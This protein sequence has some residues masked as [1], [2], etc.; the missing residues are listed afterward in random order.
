MVT[1][2]AAGKKTGKLRLKKETIKDLDAKRT[3]KGGMVATAVYCRA[4]ATG[5]GGTIAPK[6]TILTVTACASGVCQLG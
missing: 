1:K 5:G 2:K 3:V 6:A 4:R